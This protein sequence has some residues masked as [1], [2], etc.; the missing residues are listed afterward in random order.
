M[1]N[2]TKGVRDWGDSANPR[3]AEIDRRA[4]ERIATVDRRVR[5]VAAHFA[6]REVFPSDLKWPQWTSEHGTA[7]WLIVE[8][9]L[10]Q[11]GQALAWSTIFH[12]TERRQKYWPLVQGLITSGAAA[13]AG[14]AV[15]VAGFTPS[16]MAP[17]AAE[18]PP[19]KPR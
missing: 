4:D 16:F 18:G 13:L 11:P 15:D 8:A 19:R 6:A 17:I 7:L 14:L 1:A 2:Y 3:G 10:A 12:G 9:C 5:A